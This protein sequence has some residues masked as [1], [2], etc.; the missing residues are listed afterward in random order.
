[1][2]LI[3]FFFHN[4]VRVYEFGLLLEVSRRWHAVGDV[5]LEVPGCVHFIFCNG[6]VEEVGGWC[7]FC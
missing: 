6:S 3:Y 1:M 5:V 4:L 7:L 2:A